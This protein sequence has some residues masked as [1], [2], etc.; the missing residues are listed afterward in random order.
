MVPDRSTTPPAPQVTLPS[1]KPWWRRHGS[2]HS[3]GPG[4][5]VLLD[6][7][8]VRLVD[9]ATG[10]TLVDDIH[11]GLRADSLVALV[12]KDGRRTRP[13]LL[14]L[15]GIQEST[16]GTVRTPVSARPGFGR[17]GAS[18]FIGRTGAADPDLTVRQNLLMPLA[19]A[20]VVTDSAH[21]AR[22]VAACGLQDCLDALPESLGQ[23]ARLRILAARAVLSGSRVL[24]FEDPM[25]GGGAQDQRETLALLRALATAGRCVVMSTTS[26]QVA[27]VADRAVLVVGGT[28][29]A[30]V[31]HPD[32]D[33]VAEL[34]TPLSEGPSALGD[35]AA[36]PPAVEEASADS[37]A[38]SAEDTAE[39]MGAAESVDTAASNAA[40]DATDTSA[41]H[42]AP[43]VSA[44]EAPSTGLADGADQGAAETAKAGAGGPAG[45]GLGTADSQTDAGA[46]SE[47]E[48]NDGTGL[49]AIPG[50]DD[51]PHS[52]H[53][54]LEAECQDVAHVPPGAVHDALR[55]HDDGADAEHPRT[56]AGAVARA[57]R[58]ASAE[59]ASPEAAP[60]PRPTAESPARS[61]SAMEGPREAVPANT[62]EGALAR[63]A[64]RSQVHA[65]AS[66]VVERAQ[67]IL[68]D[69]PGPLPDTPAAAPEATAPREHRD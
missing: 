1:P 12:D 50:L 58:R 48:D 25:A 11:L 4:T 10:D 15:S 41:D 22:T 33:T 38:K 55:A 34:L 46:A 9:P 2:F 51:D 8:S 67:Q 53:V 31:A 20:G 30:D 29:H 68:E 17:T 6:A 43:G 61:V 39:T 19:A 59:T 28:V 49:R 5:S 3:P 64:A 47:A 14:T 65:P 32:A 7:R 57:K 56:I 24:F 63:L 35:P 45:E 23:V 18:A 54:V 62:I 13:L 42:G 44:T 21:F 16:S 69:L 52:S 40:P 60:R 37:A 66:D 36:D 26:P 27:A